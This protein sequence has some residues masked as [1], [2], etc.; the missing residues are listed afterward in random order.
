MNRYALI[1]D[2][3]AH[4]LS[5]RLHRA[6]AQQTGK[7]IEY[8]AIQVPKSRMSDA[9]LSFFREGGKGL[10]ITHPGKEIAFSLAKK[11]TVCA[12]A[13]GVV[14]TLWCE[15]GVLWGDNT[16]GIGCYRGYIWSCLEIEPE[17]LILG[18]GGAARAV[19]WAL[20]Q[21]GYR[22]VSLYNRTFSNAQALLKDFPG[23][24]LLSSLEQAIVRPTLLIHASAL[25][26]QVF[27]LPEKLWQQTSHAFDLNY[28]LSGD[29]PFLARAR[30]AGAEVQGGFKMLI[31]QA[32][33]AFYAWEG[34]MPAPYPAEFG[35]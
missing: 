5:P 20:S 8:R 34:V 3:V 28:T 33:E 1:G 25:R 7:N 19:L 12:Q 26:E 24:S 11:H 23:V 32:R 27:P 29:T 31:E 17:V 2:P 18:A 10:N 21:K 16:D 14:N 4:S 22:S 13:I 9:I 30:S 6:F 35:A 15:D